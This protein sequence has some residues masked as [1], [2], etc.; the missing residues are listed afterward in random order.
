MPVLGIIASQI[1]GHLLAPSGAY[2]TIATT[3][4]GSSASSIT[5]SSIPSTYTHLQ[6][7][8]IVR[9]DRAANPQDIFQVRFNS[10]T[11][12][13]YASHNL[14]G[15]GAAVSVDAFSSTSNPWSGICAGATAASNVFGAAVIDILDYT[16][17]S[18]NKT[19]RSLTGIENNDSNGR[20]YFSS[21]LWFATPAA[22][23]TVTLSPIYGSNFITY[24]SFALYGIRGI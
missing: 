3:T 5:F 4:L 7:R 10:D 12:T 14:E 22:I 15:T 2:D 23:T 9:S 13:N 24:S 11:G 6:I 20:L 17:T 18:K 8:G 16:S 19:L 21:S 1:S